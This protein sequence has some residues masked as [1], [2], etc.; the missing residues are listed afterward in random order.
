MAK[1]ICLNDGKTTGNTH[2]IFLVSKIL[3]FWTCNFQ[4]SVISTFVVYWALKIHNVLV[5]CR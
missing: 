2:S 5:T 3:D 4:A 1:K